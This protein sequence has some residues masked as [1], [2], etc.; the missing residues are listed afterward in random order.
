MRECLRKTQERTFQAERGVGSLRRVHSWCGGIAR[1]QAEWSQGRVT[2]DELRERERERER[3][4][5]ACVKPR[6]LFFESFSQMTSSLSCSPQ[7]EAFLLESHLYFAWLNTASRLCRRGSDAPLCSIIFFSTWFGEAG[8]LAQQMKVK[9]ST[10]FCAASI[11][12]RP[13]IKLVSFP[14]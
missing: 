1:R 6:L 13:V 10:Q 5:H 7:E 14:K 3:G 12:M 9:V 4:T 2:G 8:E 11:L